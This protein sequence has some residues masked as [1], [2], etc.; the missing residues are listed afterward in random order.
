LGR[1]Q[2]EFRIA[3]I[4]P[5]LTCIFSVPDGSVRVWNP[6]DNKNA[7]RV[8]APLTGAVIGLIKTRLLA[9]SLLALD[10]WLNAF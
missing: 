4:H 9:R 2:K 3:P 7:G 8:F 5:V 6:D 10:G 1:P